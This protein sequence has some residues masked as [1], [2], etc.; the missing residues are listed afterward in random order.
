MMRITRSTAPSNAQN[1]Q[2][3]TKST[4]SVVVVVVELDEW[5]ALVLAE[6]S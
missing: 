5:L 2:S 6:S 3:E 1:L 4:L